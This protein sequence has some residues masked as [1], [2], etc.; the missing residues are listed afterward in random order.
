MV[1]QS[2]SLLWKQPSFYIILSNTMDC[3]S[4][5]A[6]FS[7]PIYLR[8]R[9]VGGRNSICQ[10]SHV[11]TLLLDRFTHI[12]QLLQPQIW[13]NELEMGSAALCGP[14]SRSPVIQSLWQRDCQGR[15]PG[16]AMGVLGMSK[17]PKEAQSSA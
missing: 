16:R 4:P 17:Y 7:R 3:F 6:F 15:L 11:T 2:C 14:S 13:E 10:S 5:P 8:G 9:G 12:F 1:A